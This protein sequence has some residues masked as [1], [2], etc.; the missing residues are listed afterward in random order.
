MPVGERRLL[1]PAELWPQ[2]QA[3]CVKAVEGGL[4]DLRS[5]CQAEDDPS[6]GREWG[7]LRRIR[8]QVLFQP[9]TEHGPELADPVVAVRLPSC[10]SHTGK[11][12]GCRRAR[13]CCRP[14][15]ERVGWTATA[16]IPKISG[17]MMKFS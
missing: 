9:L 2:E 3:L 15:T 7:P 1:K 16:E 10:R 5:R 6:W 17:V 14:S 11:R 13:R 8:A 12:S 4:L